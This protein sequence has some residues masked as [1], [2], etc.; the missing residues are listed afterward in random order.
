QF[1]QVQEGDQV[2]PGTYFMQIVDLSKMVV[3]GYVNQTDSHGL[4]MGQRATIHL[5]AYPD[6]ALPGRL[7]ALGA[8]ASAGAGGRGRSARDL[9]V[10]NIPVRFAIDA[11]D[12]RVIPDL[13]AS[14]DVQFKA[15]GKVLQVPREAL[16]VENGKTYA[17]VRQGEASQKREIQIGPHNKTHAIVLAGLSEGEEVV[18]EASPLKPPGALGKPP[19]S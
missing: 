7:T 15:E 19:E 1:G 8:M 10:K 16:I 6:L 18:V 13:S 3:N 4:V 2:Y 14:A 9:Y 17:I 12:S 11:K 5:E